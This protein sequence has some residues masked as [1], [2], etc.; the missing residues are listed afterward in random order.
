MNRSRR[1]R[2]SSRKGLALPMAIGAIVLIGMILAGVFFTATQEN[3]VGRNTITQERAFR[4]AEYGLNNAYA[5]WNNSTM[6]KLATGAVATIGDKQPSRGFADTVRVTHLNTNTYLLV[7]TGYAGSGSTQ[8]LHRTSNVMRLNFPQI[9]VLAALTLRGALKLG[10]SSFIDG[11]DTPPT[12][13]TDCGPTTSEQP[14]IAAT[15]GDSG[16]ISLSGCK[17][18][19]CVEGNPDVQ[20]NPAAG[21]DSTYFDYGNGITWA[22]LTAAATISMPASAVGSTPNPSL[23]GGGGCNTLDRMNWGDPIRNT[24]AGPCETY[25]PI[26]YISDTTGN[27]HITGGVGQ[28]VLLVDGDLQV[29]GG[30][31]WYGPVIVKGHLTTQ[32]T[33]GH[34]NGAVMAADVD[35]ELNNLLGNALVTYSSCAIAD[36]MIGAGIPTK[37]K[38]RSWS[39]MYYH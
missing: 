37:L 21:N 2:F 22:T 18:F 34:F 35:L 7:S 39:E 20:V 15:R 23:T 16:T 6:S 10:G 36:A 12:G 28:G 29:E 5:N 4:A 3:R 30:F 13:W 1:L 33:G 27:T 32:G 25:F 17:N 14:G 8:A 26:V 38:Q 9:N 31:Q 19:T 24:P 11:R